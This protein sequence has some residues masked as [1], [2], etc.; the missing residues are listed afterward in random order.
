M[1]VYLCWLNSF[2]AV[3]SQRLNVCFSACKMSW[4]AN[5]RKESVPPKLSESVV[6]RR[7]RSR[8]RAPPKSKAPPK[9]DSNSKAPK[10]KAKGSAHKS[11][12]QL[13][14]IRGKST[15]HISAQTIN[16]GKL[17]SSLATDAVRDLC[18]DKPC[19]QY[20]RHSYAT[21]CS[22]TEM[23]GLCLHTLAA[24][25]TAANCDQRFECQYMCEKDAKKQKWLLNVASALM[26]DET[27]LFPDVLKLGEGETYCVRHNKVCPVRASDILGAG[28]SCKTW[29]KANP[30][31]WK[32]E[33]GSVLESET[34]KGGSS[35]TFYAVLRLLDNNNIKLLMIENSDELV[36][37]EQAD[38][39]TIISMLNQR[40]YRCQTVCVDAVEFG[41]PAHRRR[42]Y[43]VAVLVPDMLTDFDAFK[44]EFQANMQSMRRVPPSALD[45]LHPPQHPLVQKSLEEWAGHRPST[46]QG[47]TVDSIMSTLAAKR[48]S[49]LLLSYSQLECR[50][51]TQSSPWYAPLNHRMRKVLADQQHETRAD[52]SITFYDIS[53]SMNRVPRS[54]PHHCFPHVICA[55]TILPGSFFWISMPCPGS[56]VSTQLH[57]NVPVERYIL[58]DELLALQGWPVHASPIALNEHSSNTKC[59]LAGNAF[60]GSVCL[61]VF[62]SAFA[63]IPWKAKEEP[64][65]AKVDEEAVAALEMARSM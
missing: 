30:D 9:Q 46:L 24:E 61:S 7:S 43:L 6:R 35:D 18:A 39:R 63:A 29:S 22:G 12:A 10:A 28:I 2:E 16:D 60:A 33:R 42:A 17:L 37:D 8:E 49:P 51:S 45:L 55:P 64:Q 15:P 52:A 47:S 26:S 5:L 11:A 13:P 48:R 34:S 3:G 59:S 1:F 41:L 54:S 32:R 50:D 20:G 25:F 4:L 58:P 65:S 44:G 57:A 53:Q 14:W 36:G 21:V 38:W 40:G 31:R 56:G 27:C 23:F 62:V 19:L